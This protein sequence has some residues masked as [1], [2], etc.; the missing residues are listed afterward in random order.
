M[1]FFSPEVPD[2]SF[3]DS[4][5]SGNLSEAF[6]AA[7]V[8]HT[9]A[10]SLVPP[11]RTLPRGIPTAPT[12]NTLTLATPVVLVVDS[13][14]PEDDLYSCSMTASP[15]G[16][17]AAVPTAA[18]AV[19]TTPDNSVRPSFALPLGGIGDSLDDDPA[20][21]LSPISPRARGRRPSIV[22]GAV[23]IS[24][25]DG[26]ERHFSEVMQAEI[27]RF[28]ALEASQ[29]EVA[30]RMRRGLPPESESL[31]SAAL[32][33]ARRAARRL[34]P[35]RLLRFGLI[36]RAGE[37]A[38]GVG[39]AQYLDFQRWIG[40]LLV[41]LVAVPSALW[42]LW[43][44][45]ATPG[46]AVD[47]SGGISSFYSGA[48]AVSSGF[49]S[50]SLP[51]S[52]TLGTTVIAGV[53]TGLPYF[54]GPS[55]DYSFKTAL[56]V[57]SLFALVAST[58]AVVLG[59]RRSAVAAAPSSSIL[60]LTHAT[61]PRYCTLMLAQWDHSIRNHRSAAL[62]ARAIEARLRE[63]VAFDRNEA[64]Q[65]ADT[66]RQRRIRRIRMWSSYI[67]TAVLC[68]AFAVL[69]LWLGSGSVDTRAAAWVVPLATSALNACVPFVCRM[70]VSYLEV[71]SSLDSATRAQTKRVFLLKFF[72]FSVTIFRLCS[73]L[74]TENAP[75][76][77]PVSVVG[78][79]TQRAAL[80]FGVSSTSVSGSALA[81]FGQEVW[82]LALSDCA[83]TLGIILTSPIAFLAVFRVKPGFNIS[84]AT[85]DLLYKATVAWAGVAVLPAVGILLPCI[86]GLTALARCYELFV[87]S[88]PQFAAGWSG[89]G[90]T[91]LSYQLLACAL[92]IAWLVFLMTALATQH[93][94]PHAGGRMYD[95]FLEAMAKVPFLWFDFSLADAV[96]AVFQPS[97]LFG[98]MV[99]AVLALNARGADVARTRAA[100]TQAAS[101][102]ALLR[103]ELSRTSQRVQEL[104]DKASARQEANNRQYKGLAERY[105]SLRDRLVTQQNMAQSLEAEL[106]TF[107]ADADV[108]VAARD[109]LRAKLMLRANELRRE[110]R[111]TPLHMHVDV[112][113]LSVSVSDSSSL[114]SSDTGHGPGSP[115]ST[116][117]AS[118]RRSSVTS[119]QHRG[120]V[121]FNSMDVVVDGHIRYST[122][123]L[124]SETAPGPGSPMG[125]L[126]TSPTA[127]VG[128]MLAKQ[129][130]E[131]RERAERLARLGRR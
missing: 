102:A 78:R 96:I 127:D 126:V 116:A 25:R 71:H 87:W 35:S 29:P 1:T 90:A 49:L 74:A 15:R 47:W 54:L 103:C 43:P 13:A 58:V 70:L 60:A 130:R 85:V 18:P 94:G 92:V 53:D 121:P 10:P 66:S 105:G 31:D 128:D 76:T 122:H 20:P 109:K 88:R 5:D 113:G 9:K 117:I 86:L 97:V 111:N 91:L 131:S 124:L 114:S 93:V 48:M 77:D 2:D 39:V 100:A 8:T 28:R 33:A 45:A 14:V 56:S 62:A 112:P 63:T 6:D 123:E 75:P 30:A 67:I 19:L 99:M 84:V 119:G 38:F 104:K 82:A 46:L 69:I 110:T 120:H 50:A 118:S 79:L 41:G 44:A 4:L 11:L 83:V 27:S 7:V 73:A 42:L 17:P 37:A 101:D 12:P 3:S 107:M 22:P 23:P 81:R 51:P 40:T 65:A 61:N 95:V 36:R 55:H 32:A 80:S 57:V 34:R 21:L 64:G 59:L 26:R 98:A 72:N 24:P 89:R 125:T 52:A 106:N 115:A 129:V 68:T 108:D 16:L